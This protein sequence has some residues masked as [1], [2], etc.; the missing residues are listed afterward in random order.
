MILIHITILLFIIH[1]VFSYG[2]V[3]DKVYAEIT[4][5]EYDIQ[6]GLYL[7][8]LALSFSLIWC[9]L[10][11]CFGYSIYMFI[12]INVIMMINRV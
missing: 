3:V 1:F 11:L 10:W 5:F 12:V 6:I 8:F 4:E 2:W 7:V 9:V